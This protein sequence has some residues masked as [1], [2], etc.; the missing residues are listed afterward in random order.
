MRGRRCDGGASGGYTDERGDGEAG[1]EGR[2]RHEFADHFFSP[3]TGR[4]WVLD[5]SAGTR[6]DNGTARLR[7]GKSPPQ[8]LALP[9]A[10]TP[11]QLAK[12]VATVVLA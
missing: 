6:E 3:L 5:P 11:L 10:L 12:A 2:E 8:A 7:I 1:G 4:S 9:W